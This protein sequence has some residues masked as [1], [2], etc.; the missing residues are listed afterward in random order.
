M[1]VSL[2][3]MLFLH[4]TL[5]RLLYYYLYTGNNEAEWG[6]ESVMF[7]AFVLTQVYEL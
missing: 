4:L 5:F 1:N 7:L 3:R 6:T 2:T